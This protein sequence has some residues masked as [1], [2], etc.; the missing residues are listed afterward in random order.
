MTD[1][2]D[3][4]ETTTQEEELAELLTAADA[5]GFPV[6]SW[7]SG[8]VPRTVLELD[9]QVNSEVRGNVS[10]IA[11]G[12]FLDLGEGGWLT[13][14]AKSIFNEERVAAVITRGDATLT[15]ASN[16]GPYTIGLRSIWISTPGGLRFTNITGGTLATSGT[17]ALSW[18]AEQA[19]SDYNVAANTLTRMVT[20]LAGV[21]VNNPSATWITQTG[22]DEESDEDLRTRCRDKWAILGT[23]SSESAYAYWSRQADS[24]VRRVVVRSHD[25]EG[26]TTDG[27]VTIVLAGESGTVS[28]G[29]RDAVEAYIEAR[30]EIC[31]QLHYVAASVNTTTVTATMYVRAG[32]R[33]QAEAD[34][35]TYLDAL[36]AE[37]EI[38][39]TQYRS[40]IIE[41]LMTPAGMTNCVLFAPA[42]DVVMSW[43]EIAAFT[44]NFTW[45]EV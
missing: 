45:V 11:K 2:A 24:E 16:A 33:A 9:A 10:D 4:I 39:G 14:L 40:A 38:G 27:H 7:Q 29:A 13:L 44:P 43:D 15:C 21:T 35:E 5:E 1:L 12:G 19:G 6:T 41:A 32:Y 28:S 23:G 22:A 8:S 37:I 30:R 20:P 26:V 31:A 3:L 17:L 18:E 25:D 36:A 42:N 34:A